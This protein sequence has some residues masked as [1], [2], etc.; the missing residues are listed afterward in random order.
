LGAV[1]YNGKIRYK[2]YV[3]YAQFNQFNLFTIYLQIA[4]VKTS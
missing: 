3:C 2:S 4:S 1:D